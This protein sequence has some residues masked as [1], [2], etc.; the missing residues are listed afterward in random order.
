MANAVVG[1][2]MDALKNSS[3]RQEHKTWFEFYKG[4]I[5]IGRGMYD[6][7]PSQSLGKRNIVDSN[8]T[9]L[10]LTHLC[11]HYEIKPLIPV[12]SSI[13]VVLQIFYVK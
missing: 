13:S 5:A 3:I 8:V 11:F 7:S 4:M 9:L 1:S 2:I 12:G 10:N 6:N